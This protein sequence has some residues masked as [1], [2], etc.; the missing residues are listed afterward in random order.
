M[1]CP[2]GGNELLRSNGMRLLRSA[3]FLAFP[4]LLLCGGC[5]TISNF[6]Q[7]ISNAISGRTPRAAAVQMEDQ[8]FPDERRIGI[9]RL[10]AFEFGRQPPYT[11][12]YEQIAQRDSDWLVRATAIRALNRSR[13]SEATPIFIAALDDSNDHVRLEATKA[14]AN[15]PDANA[16]PKLIKLVNDGTENRDVRIAAADALGHFKTVE[17]ARTLASQLGG[18]E[19]GVAWQAHHSLQAITGEDLRYDESAWLNFITGPGKPLG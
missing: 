6:N 7:R 8:Y 10:S 15:I 18:R 13:W 16:V 4:L 2:I 9:N 3:L 11:K 12:R 5:E 17:V 19:F 14:L 1:H